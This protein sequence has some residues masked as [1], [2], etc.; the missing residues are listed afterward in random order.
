MALLLLFM[1]Q[2]AAGAEQFHGLLWQFEIM[3]VALATLF[4]LAAF[5]KPN[6]P[7]IG[8]VS[9]IYWM[10]AAIS[11]NKVLIYLED[12]QQVTHMGQWQLTYLF[13]FTGLLMIVYSIFNY[14]SSA[15]KDLS[16]IDKKSGTVND[17]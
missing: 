13:G 8:V 14:L 15:K 11:S 6:I 7:M 12:G 4:L 10:F 9:G 16:G 1:V 2:S 5:L 17:W 3:I